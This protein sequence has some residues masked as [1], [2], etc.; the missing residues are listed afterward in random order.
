MTNTA[1]LSLFAFLFLFASLINAQTEPAKQRE[2]RQ[3]P[4][5]K[6]MAR[7][8]NSEDDKLA[9]ELSLS[10]EQKAQFRK[11][12]E[13]YKA[14]AK[15]QR[16]ESKEEMQKMRAE[17]QAAHKAVLNAE[18]ARKYDEMIAKRQEKAQSNHKARKEQRKG[19]GKPR[20]KQAPE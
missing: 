19:G 2:G 1:K 5:D 13:E 18:Q 14:K 17:R 10:P 12:N 11:I 20:G 9:T 8:D 15:A 7:P 6:T 4:A 3:A 16:S